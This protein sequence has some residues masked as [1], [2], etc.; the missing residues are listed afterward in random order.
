MAA[1]A[2]K[3]TAGAAGF[4]CHDALHSAQT[5]CTANPTTVKPRVEPPA[6]TISILVR[7]EGP[8]QT[9]TLPGYHSPSVNRMCTRQFFFGYLP[10]FGLLSRSD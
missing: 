4:T 9:V 1:G 3:E 10:S 2:C 5:I 8:N 7:L 6:H